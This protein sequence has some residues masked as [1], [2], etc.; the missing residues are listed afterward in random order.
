MANEIKFVFT[1]DTSEF[2]AAINKVVKKAN[3]TKSAMKGQTEEQ[4][5]Q[6][7]LQKLL[8]EEYRKASKTAGSIHDIEKKIKQ[9]QSEKIRLSKQLNDSTLSR[10]KRLEKIV[11]LS[12]TEARLAG[13]NVAGGRGRSAARGRL[14]RGVGGAASGVAGRAGFGGAAT[15]GMV[16][17]S[18]AVAL[19]A[20]AA[21][22]TG[23]GLIVAAVLLPLIAGFKLL[24]GS[25]QAASKAFEMVK[26]AQIAGKTLEQVQAEQAAGM[27]GGDPKDNLK[28]FKDLGLVIDNELLESLSKSSKALKA[29][30]K[31]LVNVLMPIFEKIAKA[32]RDIVIRIGATAAGISAQGSAA[33]N[34]VRDVAENGSLAQRLLLATP[35][36]YMKAM[37]QT[38]GAG[39]EAYNKYIEDMEQLMNLG[40][41]GAAS[42]F[43]GRIK[44]TDNLARIGI[45]KGQKASELQT[46]KASLE[47]QRET[48]R[49]TGRPLINAI[50]NA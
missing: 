24:T 10:E 39:G 38:R 50:I 18:A 21:A 26:S 13:L 4:K 40:F 33:M 37:Y 29:F 2:D 34:K 6:V 15:G 20:T 43:S 14:L 44:S 12:K 49:N 36:G 5:T 22:A 17:G 1:G 19:G 11:Q 35:A 31:Q 46:L 41:S 8:N 7:K 25:V 23:I 9:T 30:G 47:A 42:G 32:L 27:F 16:A 3:Q 45:F 28:L 48:A